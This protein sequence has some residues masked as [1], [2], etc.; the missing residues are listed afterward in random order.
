MFLRRVGALAID[1]AIIFALDFF[2]TIALS[3]VPLSLTIAQLE[4]RLRWPLI[5]VYFIWFW[6]R[7][8]S[9]GMRQMQLALEDASGGRPTPVAAA[10]RFAVLGGVV[11]LSGATILLVLVPYALGCMLGLYPH[12]LL[13]RTKV[14]HAS[15]PISS[16]TRVVSRSA[17]AVG[18]FFFGLMVVGV[19]LG[20][21]FGGIGDPSRYRSRRT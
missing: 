11:A 7:G 5:A 13:A 6:T 18:L 15:Q 1:I 19:L 4:E 21:M 3:A 17:Y 2:I 16:A 9:P 20:V 12:D 8:G 10:V 14:R